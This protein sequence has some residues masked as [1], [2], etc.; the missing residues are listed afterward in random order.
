[1]DNTVGEME[2]FVHTARLQS[3]SAAGRLLR[4]SPS[5]VS[6]LVTRLEERLKTRLVVRTTR[7]LQLT[8]E[9]EVY[10][11]RAQRILDDIKEAEQVVSTGGEA[12][13]RGRLRVSVSVAFGVR[14]IVPL[15]PEFLA[16]YPLVQL[17]LSLT[18][19]IIDIVE[20]RADVAIRS[21]D[22]RDTS[23]KARKL[24]DSRRVIVAAPA[25]LERMG[26]PETPGDLDRHN[27]MTFNFRRTW[28]EWPFRDPATGQTFSKVVNGNIEVNNGPT[29]RNLCIAGVGLAR[30]GAF[31]VQPD[32][33]AGVLVPVLEP[34]NTGDVEHIHAVY[35]GHPHLA[36][37]IRA[38]ID[39]LVERI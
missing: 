18:D 7:S 33:D 5:A 4:M 12:T 22:L 38:L 6:K 28:E 11:E 13:P 24:M 39:F 19:G 8:P 25:Y 37:R 31:H 1:M 21:G 29:A 14:Y 9:G 34:F 32:I 15:V 3:F 10:L 30:V 35:P 27:C 23:L 17:D 26:T 20:E 16:R 2:V 36:S